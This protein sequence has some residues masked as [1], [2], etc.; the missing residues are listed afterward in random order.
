[1]ACKQRLGPRGCC[2]RGGLN[3]KWKKRKKYTSSGTGCQIRLQASQNKTNPCILH[4]AP[5]FVSTN[6]NNNNNNN[7][8]K[9]KKKNKNKRRKE[10]EKETEEKSRESARERQIEEKNREGQKKR[11]EERTLQAQ[12]QTFTA[13]HSLHTPDQTSP[14]AY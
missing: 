13:R 1:M 8:K 2:D 12:T 5:V 10:R 3:N 11:K 6:N 14:C 7:K 4:G 9:K